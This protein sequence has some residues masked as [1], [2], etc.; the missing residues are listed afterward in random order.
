MTKTTNRARAATAAARP[1]TAIT[2]SATPAAKGNPVQAGPERQPQGSAEGR[3]ERGH[4]P[5]R[6]LMH[7]RIEI[8]EGGRSRKVS[9]ARG[10]ADEMSRRSAQR[11][12]QSASIS[13]ESLSHG[14]GRRARRQRTLDQDEKHILEE[15]TKRLQTELTTNKE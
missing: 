8:R 1:T 9:E 6:D 13:S 10:H 11:R 14:P 15:F 12:P 4:H 3:E 7:Q 2:P 5:A